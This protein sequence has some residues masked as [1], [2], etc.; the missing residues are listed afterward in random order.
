MTEA[1]KKDTADLIIGG[2][3]LAKLLLQM[4]M[5]AA[6]MA[7]LSEEEKEK[8]YREAKEGFFKRPSGSLNQV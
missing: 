5:I 3:E 2:L 7:G 4:S 8:M 1:K 6:Q